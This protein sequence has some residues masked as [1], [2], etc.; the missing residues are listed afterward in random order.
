MCGNLVVCDRRLHGWCAFQGTPTVKPN[1]H[2]HVSCGA[3]SNLTCHAWWRLNVAVRCNAPPHQ[4]AIGLAPPPRY[5]SI[6][7]FQQTNIMS[8]LHCR[9]LPGWVGVVSRRLEKELSPAI[10]NTVANNTTTIPITWSI[11]FELRV[12][13]DL[14][15]QSFVLHV[16]F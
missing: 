8:L 13:C 11:D 4:T 15:S 3:R 6:T 10:E 12:V 14:G 5:K 7:P 2:I 9:R 1:S 16:T